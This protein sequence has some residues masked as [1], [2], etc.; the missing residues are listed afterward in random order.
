MK[1]N[2]Y[3]Q[4]AILALLTLGMVSC[5]QEDDFA[6]QSVSKEITPNFLTRSGEASTSTTFGTE[7]ATIRILSKDGTVDK[8]YTYS[9]GGWCADDILPVLINNTDGTEL[10]ACSPSISSP[11]G[12]TIPANQS[13]ETNL[14]N[15]DWCVSNTVNLDAVSLPSVDFTMKHLLCKVTVDM[16]IA[17]NTTVTDARIK[18]LYSELTYDNT[19]VNGHNENTDSEQ[20]VTACITENR[21]T[22]FVAPGTYSAETDFITLS[23]NGR[24]MSVKLKENK[25]LNSGCHY[26]FKL[27]VKPSGLDVTTVEKDENG[28]TTISVSL[29]LTKE[30]W[31]KVIGNNQVIQILGD[32]SSTS[33]QALAAV[34]AD[35]TGI[36]LTL[37]NV[38]DESLHSDLKALYENT[39][40]RA[41]YYDATANTW[42][43]YE[44]EGLYAWNNAVQT[45]NTTKLTLKADINLPNK[46]LTSDEEI[47]VDSD[48]KPSGSNWATVSKLEGEIDGQNHTIYGLKI[49]TTNNHCGFVS[50]QRANIK[51]LNIKQSY[52]YSTGSYVGGIVAS[53]NLAN[54]RIENCSF[55]GIVTGNEAVGGIAGWA[56]WSSLIFSSCKNSGKIVG[57]NYVGGIVGQVKLVNSGTILTIENCENTGTVT[58]TSSV[59][60]IYGG[61][62]TSNGSVSENNNTSTGEVI[63]VTN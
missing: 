57:K 30:E 56:A 51:N 31:E 58:G 38:A 44:P 25:L 32:V 15:A 27:M 21:A 20:F 54:I 4:Y 46:D 5:S 2:N 35:K 23:V 49:N 63:T 24:S 3:I 10:Q 22:A 40:K 33:Q 53:F 61:K 19:N 13:N 14:L 12:F 1:K 34:L 26:V 50:L 42:Y 48:G 39:I 52:L 6:P 36:A 41:S 62:S 59:A 11:T 45:V 60:G 16:T 17:E 8:T 7:G 55:D 18:N 28:F 9:S 47:T 37:A 43:V 29:D